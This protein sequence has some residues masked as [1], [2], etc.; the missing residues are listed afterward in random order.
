[1]FCILIYL[2]YF[3]S[4]EN[5]EHTAVWNV[6]SDILRIPVMSLIK[7]KL[8]IFKLII[9]KKTEFVMKDKM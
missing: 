2:L 8:I 3:K 9:D 1:M 6:T 5:T 4:L 7:P